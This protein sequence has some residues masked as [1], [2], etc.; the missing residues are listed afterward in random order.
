MNNFALRENIH[1][2]V[3]TFVNAK[4]GSSC[5]APP[6]HDCEYIKVRNQLSGQA[7]QLAAKETATIENSAIRDNTL[8]RRAQEETRRLI[9]EYY[10]FNS[11]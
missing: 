9:I 7:W 2:F 5:L 6:V 8:Q 4:S 11:E 3:K 1:P 10:K